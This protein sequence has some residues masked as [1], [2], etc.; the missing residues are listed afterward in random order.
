MGEPSA[1][2]AMSPV[3]IHVDPKANRSRFC[4]PLNARRASITSG[5]IGRCLPVLADIV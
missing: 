5:G 3:S 1:L 2:T 4:S